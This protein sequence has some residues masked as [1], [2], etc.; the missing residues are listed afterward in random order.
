MDI[1][2]EKEYAKLY[3]KSGEEKVEEFILKTDNGIIKNLF[4]K[5]KI[6]SEDL[7]QQ[8]YDLITPYGYGG[9]II[10]EANNKE[11][12]IKEYKEEFSKYC[13]KNNVVSEFIRFHPIYKNALDVKEIYDVI[14]S[15]K[16]VG[17]NIKDFDDPVQSDFSKNARREVRQAL[18]K[19]IKV[20]VIEQPSNFDNFKKLYYE[21]MN[22]NN[23]NEEYYFD[24]KYFNTILKFFSNDVLLVELEHENEIMASELYF[25]KGKI[26]HAHLLGSNDKLLELNAG[27]LLEATAAEW[28]KKNGFKYIHHGGGRTSD[29]EDSLFKYKKKF[30]KNTEFDFYVGKK[31]W[32]REIYDKLVDAKNLSEEEKNSEFFPLYR[33]K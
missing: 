4:M 32:N 8:Y 19:D 25:T 1:Y 22:R 7:D 17:T 18:K 24:D 27:S 5:R 31:I 26:L 29:P 11:E 21:T 20:H 33:I 12:L 6:D 23:A 28:G 13:E 15:R 2:F 3:E 16:T 10:I 9:P 14:F 30:G